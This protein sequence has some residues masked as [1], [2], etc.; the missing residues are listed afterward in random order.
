[1][2]DY[3]LVTDPISEGQWYVKDLQLSSVH[4]VSTGKGVVVAV[5]DSGV[6]ASHPVISG[7]V[8]A[9]ADFSDS[10]LDSG[11]DGRHDDEGHGTGMASLIAGHGKVSG[12]AP[13]A[14]IM[15][16]RVAGR[17]MRTNFASGIQWAV[18]HGAE[19]INIS[20]GAPLADPREKRAIDDAILHDI[21]VVA[22]VGNV[23]ESE[24]VQYPA[25]YPGVVAVGATRRDRGHSSVSV[26]GP[27]VTVSAPGEGISSARLNH[28]YSISTGTSDSTALVS[29]VAA[30]V[31]S[32]FPTMAASEVAR[33]I[34]MTAV[35]AGAKGRDELFG[36]G[37]VN[38]LAALTATV[39]SESKTPS[40]AATQDHGS[41][42]SDNVLYR[43]RM[44]LG[45]IGLL[46]LLAA[47][48]VATRAIVIRK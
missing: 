43:W 38:P 42:Q 33:R 40:T 6:D 32:K 31:R 7:S 11:G 41:E 3:K 20:G 21:V 48:G 30:L 9:G 13:D 28:E 23:P 37:I 8:I 46:L 34:V 19:V 17:A 29:G 27:E 24:S 14:K 45:G 26:I 2:A 36:Y 10:D 12:V 35:D 44:L 39:L 15:S 22:G 16:I 1:M 4:R 25:R 5:I 47:A 18:D